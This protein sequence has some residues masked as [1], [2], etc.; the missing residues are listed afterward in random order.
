MQL[1]SCHNG[2]IHALGEDGLRSAT[3]AGT[4][5][6]GLA[7]LDDLLPGGA[8]ARGAVHE[9][10]SAPEH[11]RPLFLAALLAKAAMGVTGKE[12]A[13]CELRVASE[14]EGGDEDWESNQQPATSNQQP[15]S[16]RQFPCGPGCGTTF[17]ASQQ[18][19]EDSHV[20]VQ[21]RLDPA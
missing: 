19:S 5:R 21:R 4:F 10:L 2:K 15:P 14:E 17:A 20:S 7:A 9:L 6:S 3:P 13:G 8:F 1:I 12:V 18:P 11:G 16:P